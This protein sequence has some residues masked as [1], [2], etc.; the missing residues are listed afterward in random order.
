MTSFF[1]SNLSKDFSLILN[2]ADDYNVIIN[3]G[4]NENA[5]EFRA[6]SVI[7]RARSPYFKSALSSCWV[8]KKNGMII[9]DKKNIKP[10]VFDIILRYIYAGELDLIEQSSEDI[11]ELLIASDELLIE[12]LFNHV[13]DYFVEKQTEWIQ[14]NLY[15]VLNIAFKLNNCKKLQN[16]IL[17][18]IC[19][20]SH[21]FITSNEFLS[22]DKDIIYKVLEREELD[23]REIVVWDHL[24]KWG[25]EQIPD[26]GSEKN[27][28]NR[29][30]NEYYEDLKEIL[31]QLIP[32]IRFVDITFD[33]FN[34]KIKPYKDIIPNQIYEEIEEFY[35]KGTFPKKT[36]L[37]PRVGKFDSKI[38]KPKLAKIIIKWINKED[39][40]ISSYIFNLIYRGINI[41]TIKNKCKDQVES[42]VLIKVKNSNKIFGGY[43]SIGFHSMGYSF[44]RIH[45]SF[46][47]SSDNFIFSFE[48]DEDTQNMEISRGKAIYDI[49]GIK[50]DFGF[51]SFFVSENGL[52]LCVT[53]Y[54]PNFNSFEIYDIEE[55]ET[56]IITKQ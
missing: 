55:I 6:H 41:E 35:S 30:S 15:L 19:K 12:E 33:D 38:I 26:L 27:D 13:Q 37:S 11:Y 34:Y 14:K 46:Q 4:E 18:F 29:W 47:Y 31:N 21:S 32:L 3:V 8:T 7:L 42:L 54:E 51:D 24:I 40:W 2:D 39:F 52:G 53:S 10:N 1:Y 25:I 23:V 43:S 16:Y 17:E 36:T 20:V 44:L 28:I 50:F 56:F 49:S 9:F 45:N 48:N 22:L 5:K